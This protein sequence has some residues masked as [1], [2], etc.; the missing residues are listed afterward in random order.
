M[1][2]N[3]SQSCKFETKNEFSID[4]TRAKEKLDI[5][6]LLDKAKT[7]IQ[8]EE[9]AEAIKTLDSIINGYGTYDEVE[10]AYVL[11]EDAQNRYILNR[12]LTLQNMDSLLTFVTDYNNEGI[13]EHAEKRI[14][15]VVNS[16]RDPQTLQD[17]LDSNRLPQFRPDAK[18]RQKELL[19]EKENE[20]YAHAKQQN[21]AQTWKDFISMYPEHPKKDQ[22]EQQ[23][24]GLEVDDIFRGAYGEIPVSSQTGAANYTNSAV[25]ITNNTSYTLTIRYSGP[26]NKRLIISPNA[27]QK[28]NLK[29]GEYRVTAS[30]NSARVNNFAG[31]ERLNGEYSSSFYIS[32]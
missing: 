6:R 13:K 20:L 30:V 3:F 8:N 26:E 27:K 2:Q 23:I 25:E 19:E 9:L 10:D 11:K 4:E 14:E 1:L 17:F 24:I 21:T 18:Q 32:N 5:K 16:T 15:E 31:K 12:I 22:I 7:Q 28:V 29:S